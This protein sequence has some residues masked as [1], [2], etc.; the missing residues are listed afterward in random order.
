M[1][2]WSFGLGIDDAQLAAG[3]RGEP[4][5]AADLYRIGP[6]G[7]RGA[8]EVRATLHLEGVGADAVDPAAHGVDQVAQLLDVGLGCGV[9]DGGRAGG[10]GGRHDGVLGGHDAHLVEEDVGAVE[11]PGRAQDVR[12]RADV[13]LGAE[14]LQRVEMGVEGA[15]ADAVASRPR[16]LGHP[17]A[18]HERAGE[19]KGGADLAGQARREPGG[20]PPSRRR[21]ARP[22]ARSLRSLRRDRRAVR[23]SQP[24]RGS[25]GRC[26]V[27]LSRWRAR[28]PPAWAGPRSCF[29]REPACR[30]SVVLRG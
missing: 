20:V 14:R 24:R 8:A 22:P 19:E 29:L 4:D 9:A 1:R 30:E 12:F 23:A 7:R 6:D 21:S 16:E 26:R 3:H 17:E 5:E 27:P 15:P 13:H 28:L 2:W 18:G 25:V 10:Q 11:A